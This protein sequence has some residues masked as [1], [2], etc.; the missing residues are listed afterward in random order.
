MADRSAQEHFNGLA[1]SYHDE[2]PRHIREY[3]MDKWWNTVKYHFT[4]NPK[5]IDI[6]C[7]NGSTVA[8]L[9]KKEINAIGVDFSKELIN[10]GRKIYPFLK[11]R[12]FEGN[13]LDLGFD[14][15]TFDVASMIGMLHHI[16]S[17]EDQIRAVR[18]A[19]RVVKDD[20]VLI[21]R[22]SNPANPLFRIFWNYIFPLTS[23]IDKFGG[24][25]WIPVN[26]FMKTFKE[27]FDGVFYFTFIPN[28]T[29]RALIPIASKVESTLEKSP[30]KRLSAHYVVVLKK[31]KRK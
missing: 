12:L 2:I 22:E 21:I 26:H 5:V 23:K 17:A 18:E 13:A 31:K 28:F 24:E 8:F 30:L 9:L 7:G 20:G 14:D 19:L 25:R 6:G 11:N 10:T 4:G 1:G 29:P 3:L 15:R 27:N 16:H